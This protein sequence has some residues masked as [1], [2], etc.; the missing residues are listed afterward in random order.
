MESEVIS[1]ELSCSTIQFGE[2]NG[3]PL[4]Y[5]YLANPMDWGAWQ[6]I[7]HGV[8]RVGHDLETKPTTTTI[9]LVM[10]WNHCQHTLELAIRTLNLRD[11]KEKKRQLFRKKGIVFLVFT[12][13][14]VLYKE[15]Q[16]DSRGEISE[17]IS[18][19]VRYLDKNK[20]KMNYISILLKMYS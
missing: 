1:V 3:N 14:I 9:H 20:Y 10:W 6:V 19:F 16:K 18:I 12:V 7:L 4:Q 8:T 13:L 2:G 17:L 15:H 5:S 11:S